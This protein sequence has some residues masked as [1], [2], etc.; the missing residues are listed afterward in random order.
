LIAALF[1]LTIISAPVD[2]TIDAENILLGALIPFHNTDPRASISLGYAPNPGLARRV[3]KSEILNKIT[4]AGMAADDLQLPDSILVHRRAAEIDR[5]QVTRAILDAFTR[6]FPDANIEIMNVDIPS[7]P[8]GFGPIEISASLPVRF[9]PAGSA[10]VRLDVRGKSFAKTLFAQTSFR[11]ETT[12]PVLKNKIAA[13]SEIRTG[14]IEWKLAPLSAGAAP[15]RIDGMLAKRDLEPG[16]VLTTD[17]LYL[18]LYVRKG[19]S[20]TVKTTAGA[21]TIAATMRAKAAGKL[22][23]TIA[24]EHLS[25]EGS[26]VARIVGPRVLE[27][28]K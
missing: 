5:D 8:V 3:L 11:I 1:L 20:V 16:Q 14:D 15:D 19:D 27:V 24:V 26:T 6:R 10:F 12:Q 17:L 21:V 22:G 7:V 2:V 13:H 28:N 23:E 9:D 25:G 18:P 4:V